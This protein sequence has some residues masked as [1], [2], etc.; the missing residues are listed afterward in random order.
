[1]KDFAA[2]DIAPGGTIFL[3]FAIG[4]AGRPPQQPRATL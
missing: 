1:M 4:A 3:V 2:T